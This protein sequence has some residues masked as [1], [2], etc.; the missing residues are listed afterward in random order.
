MLVEDAP[1]GD[2][3]NGSECDFWHLLICFGV[4]VMANYNT[5][6]I[7]NVADLTKILQ[8]IQVAERHAAGENLVD[9]IGP[10][11]HLL[12]VGLRTVDGS[13]NHL[14]P[15]QSL[16]GA[17]DQVFPRLLTPHYI[18]EADGET[19]TLGPPGSGAPTVT[20]TNYDPT[21]AP[22][23]NATG[24]NNHSVVDA[25]PRIISNLIVDQTLNNRAA[26]VSA[27][28]VVGGGANGG[29]ISVATAQADAI[30]A[31]RAAAAA[32]T[33][34]A[35]A[36][37]QAA[38]TSADGA[39][40]TAQG[41]VTAAQ[42]IAGAAQ[43]AVTSAQ[44][45][46]TSELADGALAA[47]TLSTEALEMG[48]AVGAYTA[49][50][51]TADTQDDIDTLAALVVE[52]GE[53]S[54]AQATVVTE[55]G[56]L[57][58]AQAGLT[59]AQGT[60]TAAQ[61]SLSGAQSAAA[62]AL[63]QATSAHAAYDA[64]AGA[65]AAFDNLVADAGV[66]ISPDGSILIEQRSA[67]IG[68]S[69]P[70]SA[71]MAFFGQFFDHGLDLVTKGGNGKIYIPL[72]PDD[73]LYVPGGNSNF[74]VLSR[75]TPFDANGNPSPIG[76]ESQNTTTPFV[77]QNQT[78][79]SNASHQVF[80][81]EYKLVADGA[82]LGTNP[83]VVNSGHLLNNANGG[84]AT[85]K[86][87]KTQAAEKLGLTLTDAD[88]LDVPTVAVDA[89][90][91]FIA[92]TH[93]FAQ[94]YINV[95]VV[96]TT[97]PPATAPVG[98]PPTINVEVIGKF[99][100]EGVAGG[101]DMRAPPPGVA[102]PPLTPP[103]GSVAVYQ[104]GPAGT[105]HA[106]L[107]DI[108]HNAEPVIIGGFLQPDAN[109]VIDPHN[110]ILP[111][112]GRGHN[113][114]YDNELLDAHFITGDGRG[115]ENIG[116]TAVHNVFHSEHNRLVEAYKDTL[117]ATGD[118]NVVNQWLAA[119]PGGVNDRH[120]ITQLD[121]D[122]I[123]AT[124]DPV[125]KAAA[126]DALNWDGGRLFQAG[127]FVTEMQYQHLVFEEF[128]RRVQPNV[129]PFVFTNSADLDPAIVAEFAHTV[130][131]F[132]HSMLTDT[133][134]RLDN[135][136][137]V[138]GDANPLLPGDQQVGLIEAFLNPQLFTAS[139]ATPVSFSDETAVGALV[140]GM[141]RQVGNEI[142][143]FVVE[144]LRNNLLGQPL[145]L[146][147]LNLARGR[148]QGVP[149]LNDARAQLYAMT[150]AADVKP[151]T[152]WTDF[153]Q[154]LK[155]PLSVI[156]F[157]AAYGTHAALTAADVDT[158]QER[159]DVAFALVMGGSAVINKGG[160][161][162]AERTFTADNADRHDFLNA[163]GIYA[164]DGT[165]PQNDSL[166]GLNN[167]DLWIGGLAEKL[168]EFGGQL[169]STFNFIFE[170]QMEHLQNGDRFYYLSRTQG[171]NL[172][173]L[174]EPN[175]FTDLVL[176]NTDLGDIHST[177]LPANL[178][179]V[180]DFI[181]ELDREVHQENYSG[182]AAR[183]GTD[184][185]NRSNLDPTKA[186]AFEQSI[187]PM[188]LRREGTAR[189]D[190]LGNFVLDAEGKKIFDGGI[191]K[192]SGGNHVVLGGTEGNDTLLGDRGIDTIWG[193]AGNDYINAGMESDQVYGGDGDDIIEDPFGDDFLRGE[194]GD[195][196][197]VADQGI[198]LLFG[199]EGQDFIQG[200]TDAKEVF[201]GPGNDFILGGS[202]P[203]G[204]MGNE[205]DDWIEGGEGFDGLSGENSELFFNSPIIGHDILNGQGNDTDYDGESGDDIMVQ[206]AGIQRNNGMLGFDWSIQKGDENDGLIDLG[207][208]R[209]VNQ[210][211]L[212]LRDRNDSVEGASGWKH[213]DT[214]I[215]TTSPT[216]AVGDP[217][218]GIVGG[219][220]TDSMLLS[221][222]VKLIRGFEEFLKLTPG[223][224]RGQT[225]GADATPFSAL[226][227]DTTVFNPQNG[228]DILLGGA[229]SDLIVGKAGNDL[230]DGDRW[231]NVRI[232]VH[233]S[234][235]ASG[236]TGPEIASFDGLT[237]Q[238]AWTGSGLPASWQELK[239]NQVTH[240]MEGTGLTWSL[241]QLM[242][243]GLVNPGQ[244]EAVR[245]IIT[246][247]ASAADTDVALF[248]GSRADF[249]VT[250]NANGTVTV[251]DNVVT[252][253]LDAT[254]ARIPLLNDEG[255]DTLSNIEIARF[256]NYD[257]NG[258]PDG[259]FTDVFIAPRAATGAPAIVDGNLGTPTEGQALTTNTASIADLN[260]LGA[261]SFQWQVAPVGTAPD[262]A[263][264]DITGATA[265]TFTP[266]QA[267]VG[268]ILRVVT[269][270][271]D[272]IGTLER[273]ISTPTAGVGDAITAGNGNQTLTTLTVFDDVIN[274]GNG[275]DTVSYAAAAAANAGV[276]VSLAIQAA[277][278]TQAAI[279]AAIQDTGG[280][281]RDVLIGI[282]NIIGSAFNDTLTGDG[283]ANALTGGD[284]SDTLNGGAGNDSLIANVDNFHDTMDGGA[285]TD[286]ADY[287]AYAAGLTV[288]LNGATAAT[289]AGSGSTAANSD[290]LQNIENIIG[291]TGDDN[292]TGDGRA[293]VLSGGLGS[294]TLNGGLGSDTLNGG[295]DADVLGGGDNDDTLNGDAG[296]DTLT[297]GAGNDALNGGGAAD[298]AVFASGALG[299]TLS[300]NAADNIV[301]AANTTTEG[302][303]TLTSIETLRFGGVDYAVVLGSN[304]GNANL[305]GLNGTAGSQAVF[306]LGG[307]DTING[308]TGNDL[309]LGGTGSDT[310]TQTGANG[311]RD[312]VDGGTTGAGL[313]DASTDTYIVNGAAGSE[314][315][316]IYSRTAFLAANIGAVL[317]ANTEIVVTRQ[318]GAAV[319]AAATV[320]DIVSEL[321][322]I[323]EIRVNTLDVTT[324]G[325]SIG[326]VSGG[327]TVQVI[328][329]FLGTSLNFNTITID[330]GAGN[331][332]IDIT[333][334][335]SAHRIVFTGN[336]GADTVLGARAQDVV[337][338]D[339]KMDGTSRNDTLEA[340]SGNDTVNG[341]AGNDRFIASFIAN[342]D[343]GNDTYNGGAGIDTYDLSATLA[344]AIVNLVSGSAS[345]ADTGADR[346][347]SIENVTGGQ[348]G[349]FITGNA[350]ANVLSG[351]AGNDRIN[352]GAGADT[353]SGGD[354]IDIINGGAGNDS[355][356][357]GAGND[358]FAFQSGF[359]NDR[360]AD[361]D[362][363]PSGGQDHIDLSA[364]GITSANFAAHVFAFNHM[365]GTMIVVNNYQQTIVLEHV[366]ASTVT[367]DDFTLSHS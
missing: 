183:D 2:D 272:G 340:G 337:T 3:P 269:S 111:N 313:V 273:V 293:N 29:D 252:P 21:I 93:G 226:P 90:G 352:G 78:Y 1:Q 296:A 130:Y 160:V 333:Q 158:L 342:G 123:N 310:I 57:A 33:P 4:A 263:W 108:N 46:V 83:D 192:F 164:A 26:L 43:L 244:L 264:A 242:R 227:V 303:D 323:E 5:S 37:L 364:L 260:G 115:N 250:R 143:E 17:A 27:L 120:A 229:G 280:S 207:I 38:A 146:P 161:G 32:A 298:T 25:D 206:S 74:M 205:G 290:E 66:E 199:G 311:G 15:G 338:T 324:P 182:V 80:L 125:A 34:A 295:A 283:N 326:G 44:A 154:N 286:T 214:L 145:D 325:G 95:S 202:A 106:F 84:I 297:G 189:V 267:Q 224:L 361:F 10:D 343:D 292:I 81:R 317:Q 134:D 132:G 171:T 334:L 301:V 222:N 13:F 243:T 178:M 254:G 238:I 321:D 102:L 121:L 360:I 6:F 367:I 330:G 190:G 159:K 200:N 366:K 75:T 348:G 209:F 328:G 152:S 245:E 281:G 96:T 69:P 180:D 65:K 12:P 114:V 50:L 351:N 312:F 349:D 142:D 22:G 198:D 24:A 68:L 300:T 259:T 100:V 203:D 135:N 217:A 28:L 365:G 184:P 216:G 153:A 39:Y 194:G 55:A 276:T 47:A 237:A 277:N 357:G 239:L 172:L 339:D 279:D 131:R 275:N 127:R 42:G 225:V 147:T 41:N 49:A 166:G 60:L 236:P 64:L 151:Y 71:W 362:A 212:T 45:G 258:I 67:D 7:V 234:K 231:L 287:S 14:L 187:N 122:T 282:E 319:A 329:S 138:V 186:D 241:A 320:A 128:A 307:N 107:N 54:A 246:D 314:T 94:V 188:V 305:N 82:D 23:T 197:I 266:A 210:Q 181:F 124:A 177:H 327:D 265:A 112:D 150:G 133:V 347:N 193:D 247:G 126:I 257:A 261:F 322:N 9:I 345:S 101:L 136:L 315:F 204:L 211:A 20:N 87:V 103:S 76:T 77:D 271:T 233:A 336:G 248:F 228:G 256:T 79:T 170:Y 168:N 235:T 73:P 35:L 116:L 274:G 309:I 355:L 149:T 335:T 72:Q 255:T 104:F 341:F 175:T 179:S 291:G 144:A 191:L 215:G 288:T 169:G 113:F 356:R 18:N 141:S 40:A 99:L 58:L 155:H 97:Q 8:Q 185:L 176:R 19:I 11:A 331:D 344:G 56:Q 262:G 31:A 98:T 157:I 140:R 284:G 137:H 270:F 268:Q 129:D 53:L 139:G 89:Y 118:V 353:I 213:N 304:L 350:G 174:L 163:T 36:S 318:A 251:V 105:G 92:G 165:G 294:D 117:V 51:L 358:V 86:D 308:G 59:S 16:V 219:P 218:G 167:I 196:V 195:D 220:A 332:T 119:G 299:Y 61:T 52:S 346:L 30:L 363:N 48:Q 253:I 62:T 201:A 232:S 354:G 289:V 162:G 359:G 63:L 109:D 302:S 85:W 70:N 249:T 156:N 208:S 306:G 223:A 148:E 285:D 240:Q 230:I 173:N 110:A 221:Q 278:T 88:V 91:N 316:K